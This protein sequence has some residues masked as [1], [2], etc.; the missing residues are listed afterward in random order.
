L[1]TAQACQYG[2]ATVALNTKGV[3]YGSIRATR[4]RSVPCGVL[5]DT[6]EVEGV[7]SD[8]VIR[9]FQWK[10]SIATIRDFN[11]DAA[12]NEIG[13]Q[14]VEFVGD[15]V[16][17]DGD[18]VVNEVSV[19]DIT[20]LT[21]YL[22]AQPRPTTILE[23]AAHGL[24]EPVPA[25]QVAKIN[26]GADVFRGIGCASCHVPRLKLDDPRFSEPSRM[27][28]YRDAMFPAGQDPVARGL[29]PRFPIVVD[30]TADQP[31]NRIT[32]ANG[33]IVFRLGSLMVDA[34][35][36]GIVDLFSDLK[37]HRMGAR[38][39]EGIDEVGTGPAMF[40]TRTLWGVGSTAPYLHDG[41]ATTLTEAI[42]E[43][44]GEAAASRSAFLLRSHD[45]QDALMA[46][47]DNLVLF[48]MSED[49]VVV[50]PPPT[51][52]LAPSLQMRKPR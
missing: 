40:M 8:L 4:V 31:D 3:S 46:F 6:S 50:P 52:Q 10:G 48:K 15:S 1:A 27:R 33:N 5:Y 9:P 38:L 13:M 7:S 26:T 12:N 2:A 17:G 51:A 18:G 36:R 42:L 45:E 35:R 23:L 28:Q 20:A 49:E 14:A 47:L 39:A 30:L 32:D 21:V 22:A 43:H 44:G 24:V 25:E 29:D 41:R 37:R 34:Q 19:G 16:D 11:R